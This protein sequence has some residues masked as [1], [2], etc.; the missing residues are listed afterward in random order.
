M[1]KI[2][3]FGTNSA[4]GTV[5]TCSGE[6]KTPLWYIPSEQAAAPCKLGHLI[7]CVPL[8]QK[9]LLKIILK[10]KRRIHLQTRI[11]ARIETFW[12]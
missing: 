1:M 5:I 12:I 2:G 7:V 10:T 4:L 3:T 6:T 9:L 11:Y 8:F